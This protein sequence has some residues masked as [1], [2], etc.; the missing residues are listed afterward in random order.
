MLTI[1]AAVG[2]DGPEVARVYVDS[3]NDGFGELMPVAV[4]DERRVARWTETVAGGNW[5]V[6]EVDGVLA[7]FVGIGPSR[8]PVDPALGELD[9]IAV[10]RPYW[11]QGVGTALMTKAL[12][13]L[14]KQYDEAILWT[15]ANYPQAQNFYLK[16]G[17]TLT[18]HTR[19]EGHQV[20]YRR[21]FR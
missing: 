18:T 17:W 16:T 20:S 1:R 5:W 7:G 12:E 2:G 6:A 3:W 10:D 8:D 15:L 19:D 9:T 13:E 14:G 4:L 11:R 21:S